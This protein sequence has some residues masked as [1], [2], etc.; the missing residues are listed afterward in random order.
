MKQDQE[1]KKV[2]ILKLSRK[3]KNVNQADPTNDA[4]HKEV[5][6]KMVAKATLEDI[7]KQLELQSER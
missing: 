7:V 2:I 3:F 4:L 1:E 6:S 5:E